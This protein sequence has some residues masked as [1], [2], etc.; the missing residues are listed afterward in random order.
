[1]PV[2]LGGNIDARG[3]APERNTLCD[4]R[5][6]I[7][8]DNL[9]SC[10]HWTH[11][12]DAYSCYCPHCI[13]LL[14]IKEINIPGIEIQGT[15]F[16]GDQLIACLTGSKNVTPCTHIVESADLSLCI[17][18]EAIILILQDNLLIISIASATP[19]RYLRLTSLHIAG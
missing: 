16:I 10:T 9:D 19:G 18:P 14:L 1:M 8:A 6:D 4:T 13:R 12:D 2:N 15:I 5:G 11:F 3:A 7:R 17:N